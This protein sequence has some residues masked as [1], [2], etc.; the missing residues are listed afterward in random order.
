MAGKIWNETELCNLSKL[1]VLGNKSQILQTI[2]NRTWDS[3]K[4][5]AASL[6]LRFHSNVI[7]HPYVQSDVSIL[8]K[9]IPLSYYWMGFLMA[10]GSCTGCRLKLTLSKKDKAHLQRFSEYIKC[11]NYRTEKNGACTVTAQDKFLVPKIRN[12]FDWKDQKT[13]HPPD[14]SF[15]K[16]D[17]FLAWFIGYVDGDGSIGYQSGRKTC[18]LRIKVH[19]SWKPTLEKM[20]EKLFGILKLDPRPVKIDRQGY[21]NLGFARQKVLEFLKQKT[22]E[23]RLPVLARKW[24][25][26]NE[27]EVIG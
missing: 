16:N 5:K 15:L 3:I 4:L 25:K 19:K 20:S 23:L 14:I 9:E 27:K 18:Q 26:I 21:A 10:D 6:N 11:D 7:S 8:L 2:P 12:K 17:L 1:Y 24:D 13:Y 22:K